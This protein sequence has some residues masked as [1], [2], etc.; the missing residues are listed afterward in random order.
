MNVEIVESVDTIRKT[1]GARRTPTK[2]FRKETKKPKNADAHNLDSKPS[3][4]EAEVEIGELNMS[5]LDV[6]ALQQESEKMRGSGLNGSSL[7]SAQVQD[8]RHG[9]RVSRTGR[10][11]LVTVTSLFRTATGEFVKSGKR[12]HV[13]G[14]DDWGSNLRVRGVQAP[15]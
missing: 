10:R 11:F 5:Y 14:C 12:M 2:V 3:I 4:V 9:L 7:E 6:D 13:L 1:V 15:V 8:R